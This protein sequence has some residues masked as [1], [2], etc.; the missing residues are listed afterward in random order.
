MRHMV[1]IG[2][3]FR[4]RYLGAA[5]LIH[6]LYFELLDRADH[7]L[8]LPQ[9]TVLDWVSPPPETEADRAMREQG[10]RLRSA[11]PWLD[12]RRQR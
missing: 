11:F 12:E 8:M 2:C 6:R 1:T 4:S 5:N 9:L 3:D 10:V 7:A